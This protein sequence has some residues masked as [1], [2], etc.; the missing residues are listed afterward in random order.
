L[1]AQFLPALEQPPT[2]GRAAFKPAREQGG[3][4]GVGKSVQRGRQLAAMI[5]PV[6][7][8]GPWA[9]RIEQQAL[10]QQVNFIEL[11]VVG[12]LDERDA[13]FRTDT[14]DPLDLEREADIL[15]DE[16]FRHVVDRIGLCEP[17]G[18]PIGDGDRFLAEQGQ[19]LGAHAMPEA[20]HRRFRETLR[21]TR[22]GRFEAVAPIG[23]DLGLRSHGS[24]LTLNE[25]FR[26]PGQPRTDDRVGSVTQDDLQRAQT[27]CQKNGLIQKILA[28]GRLYCSGR[29]FCVL[30][31]GRRKRRNHCSHH[32]PPRARGNEEG[33]ARS[34]L[35]SN[36]RLGL[37]TCEKCKVERDGMAS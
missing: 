16:E 9:V 31:C 26:I 2:P 30:R 25:S 34:A 37:E 8:Q 19:L 32:K 20:V 12:I 4:I 15:I 3:I 18:P 10:P 13:P 23:L 14:L 27:C 33:G 28:V 29:P 36:G 21:C 6:A 1:R 22:P 24:R 17:P 11:A 7:A 35:P 5:R